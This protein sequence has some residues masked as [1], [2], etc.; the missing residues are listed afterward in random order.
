MSEILRTEIP[1][2]AKHLGKKVKDFNLN[3]WKEEGLAVMET[4]ITA[5]FLQN[6]NLHKYLL[7][8][9]NNLLALA[10]MDTFWGIDLQLYHK[11]ILNRSIWTLVGWMSI[12]L[13]KIRDENPL[14]PLN[15]N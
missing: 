10:S 3:Q 6:E 7:V 13:M 1:L 15:T 4:G 2:K 5:S 14:P 11:G 8:T 12:V 9:S